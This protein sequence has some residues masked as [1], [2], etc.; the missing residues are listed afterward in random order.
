MR[1]AWSVPR[2]TKMFSSARA[3]AEYPHPAQQG[4]PGSA[5]RN[6]AD[7]ARSVRAAAP[8]SLQPEGPCNQGAREHQA[9]EPSLDAQLAQRRRAEA[10]DVADHAMAEEIKTRFSGCWSPDQKIGRATVKELEPFLQRV[11]GEGK[12]LGRIAYG[13]ALNACVPSGSSRSAQRIV[14]LMK[15]HGVRMRASSYNH[16]LLALSKNSETEA[17]Q[18]AFEEMH[19]AGIPANKVTFTALLEGVGRRNPAETGAIWAAMKA[20][21]VR[22]DHILFAKYVRYSPSPQ[23]AIA[24]LAEAKKT[25]TK[26]NPEILR[27]LYGS[28][29][30]VAATAGRIAIATQAFED[31]VAKEGVRPEVQQWT[32]LMSVHASLGDAQSC[33]DVFRRMSDSG[34]TP[35]EATYATLLRACEVSAP[36]DVPLATSVFQRLPQKFLRSKILHSWLLRVLAASGDEAALKKHLK[37]MDAYHIPTHLQRHKYM[38]LLEEAKSQ[39]TRDARRREARL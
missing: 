33:L 12:R 18:R 14:R 21:G 27:I 34:V 23:D 6:M 31:L 13:T 11:H 38:E 4:A 10:A 26:L 7:A 28:L 37:K 32:A 29:I 35:T 19:T 15:K 22:P 5:K 20:E 2:L 16:L 1:A 39:A 24:R 25:L 30:T 8:G 36:P 9:A 17:M 3:H